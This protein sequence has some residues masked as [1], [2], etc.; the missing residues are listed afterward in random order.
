MKSLS[1]RRLRILRLRQIEH[2][3]ANIRLAR[4]D[5]ALNSLVQL[6]DRI[7]LLKSDNAPTSGTTNGATLRSQ[8]EITT[9]LDAVA[10]NM[11]QPI[12]QAEAQKADVNASRLI[13]RRKE[14]SASKLYDAASAN[15]AAALVMR[16][17]TNRPFRPRTKKLEEAL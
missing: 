1:T 15:E 6:T 3:I 8:S 17:D 2:R 10:A 9:R 4:A 5:S 7:S 14:E 13:A 12:R 11:A 16:E